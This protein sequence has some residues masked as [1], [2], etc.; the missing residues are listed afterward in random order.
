MF[1]IGAVP[2]N[3]G[4]ITVASIKIDHL[5]RSRCHHTSLASKTSDAP[6]GTGSRTGRPSPTVLG[7][8]LNGEVGKYVIVDPTQVANSVS[9]DKP[10]VGPK[11]PPASLMRR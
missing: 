10:R 9:A 5:E 3:A 8:W 6:I 11:T 2:G 1:M 4:W 7:K